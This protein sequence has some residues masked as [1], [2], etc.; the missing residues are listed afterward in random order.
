[1]LSN[2]WTWDGTTW[3]EQSPPNPPVRYAHAL[4]YD[5]AR[6]E[7]LLFGGKDH[8]GP[9]ALGDTWTWGIAPFL[10]FPLKDTA[11][12]FGDPYTWPVNSIFDHSMPLL[13]GNDLPAVFCSDVNDKKGIT[14]VIAFTGEQG[15]GQEKDG[16][17]EPGKQPEKFRTANKNICGKGPKLQGYP[18]A[19]GGSFFLGPDG[20]RGTA[21]DPI[22][23]TGDIFL[24]YDG[25]P[26]YDYDARFVPVYAAA[27]GTVVQASECKPN[28]PSSGKVEI[29]H[30]WGY[31]TVYDHLSAIA[32]FSGPVSVGQQI[33][34]SGECHAEG[35]PHLH[36]GVKLLKSS[37]KKIEVDPYGWF[38]PGS[39][40]YTIK[41][42]KLWP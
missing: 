37:G 5:V 7:V 35:A 10:E 40:P 33:G 28:D 31:S 34:V 12:N 9:N 32:V 22:N 27:S 17:R 29:D 6:G 8:P 15:L 13:D 4:A 2:T 21:D 11:G 26:G 20:V 41:N 19:T 24:S 30:P 25:H 39:D 1:M 38:G 36:F 42:V 18:K 16:D 14:H 3:T 23:Y